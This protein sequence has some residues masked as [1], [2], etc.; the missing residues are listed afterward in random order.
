MNLMRKFSLMAVLA[1]CLFAV[2]Y[3]LL[4]SGWVQG[5]R[6]DG[7]P[8]VLDIVRLSLDRLQ[9]QLPPHVA[10]VVTPALLRQ[11]VEEVSHLQPPT[12]FRAKS[13]FFTF[14]CNK[15]T[16]VRECDSTRSLP[17]PLLPL[18][19]VLKVKSPKC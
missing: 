7:Q 4:T 17:L 5:V 13:I 18:F 8:A 15:S 16:G 3:H 9:L 11:V 12:P 19:F 1:L 6:A 10:D 14:A 2:Q